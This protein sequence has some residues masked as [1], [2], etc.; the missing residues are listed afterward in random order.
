MRKAGI[1]NCRL[2]RPLIPASE[3]GM[4]APLFRWLESRIDVFAPFDERET[5]PRGVW[6]FMWH[7]IKGVKGWMALI[8]LTGLGFSGIEAAMYLMV[9]WFVDLLT[10]ETPQTI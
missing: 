8:M 4:F 10:Q 7:H 6:P 5:P 3:A 9:G 2:F 1:P